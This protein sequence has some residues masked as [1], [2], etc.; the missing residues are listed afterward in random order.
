MV[1]AVDRLPQDDSEDG[2]EHRYLEDEEPLTTPRMAQRVG[3]CFRQM[4][5]LLLLLLLLLVS[6]TCNIILYGNNRRLKLA[7][8][9]RGF[10]KPP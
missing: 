7:T 6:L 9:H 2:F 1:Y 3:P 5:I 10:S 4:G 8:F